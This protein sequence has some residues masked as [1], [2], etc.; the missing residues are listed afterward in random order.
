ME[1]KSKSAGKAGKLLQ[2]VGFNLGSEEFGI[3]IQNVREINKLCMITRIPKQPDFIEG[4]INLR[5]KIIHVVDLRKRLGMAIKAA[6]KDSRI[7]VV[8]FNK[9]TIGFIVDAVNEVM[10]VSID[11]TEPPP[12][13]SSGAD[14]NFIKAVS[15]LEDRLLVLLDLERIMGKRIK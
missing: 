8:E 2:L 1:T 5:G 14:I 10:R 4:I 6:D 12:E 9:R 7:I 11:V 13:L 15:K 3:E